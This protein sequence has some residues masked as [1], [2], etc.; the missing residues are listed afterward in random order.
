M[1][2]LDGKIA[3]VTGAGRVGSIGAVTAE[4]FAGEG[5]QVAVA[6]LNGAGAREV[7]SRITASGGHAIA[8]TVDLADRGAVEAMVTDTVAA[9]GGLDVLFNNAAAIGEIYRDLM[10]KDGA[11]GDLDPEV[12]EVSFNVNVLATA[13]ATRHAI[14]HFLARGGGSVINTSSAVATLPE[15]T[16][17]VY[18]ATKAAI[19]SLTRSTAIQYGK[20]GI[21]ANAIAP[22]SR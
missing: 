21:R 20:A 17:T 18:A 14:P 8:L 9:L 22:E 1:G 10:P 15:A 2:R 3:L 6:D 11:I 5:A 7:A 12:F 16:R 13:L 4:L 19:E